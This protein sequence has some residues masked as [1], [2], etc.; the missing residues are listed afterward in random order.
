MKTI[1]NAPAKI[2]LCLKVNGKRNDSYHNLSMI[3]Q[4]ISIF[5]TM[6]IEIGKKDDGE[7]ITLECNLPYVPTDDKNLVVKVVKYF[8]EKY[9]IDDKI[10]IYL[11]K[12]IP[13]CGGLGGGSSDAASMILF[14]NEYYK[15]N[16]NIDELVR[17]ASEFGSDI[18]FFIYGKECLCEGRGEKITSLNAFNNYYILIATP[19]VRISTKDIFEKYD[20]SDLSNDDK[21][22]ALLNNCLNAIKSKDL[23]MLTDNIFNNLESV[24]CECCEEVSIFKQRMIDYGACASLMSGSGPSVFG[25]FGSNEKALNCKNALKEEYKDA[26][27]YAAKP[28]K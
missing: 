26:F 24:T 17:I 6:E 20:R 12:L 23:K 10:S 19:N 3:M 11:K 2:N 22:T 4:T 8:Y 15:L 1:I 27:V 5:D 28:I 18:P 14:L 9:N 13:T 25:I 16:L 21:D 7:Q